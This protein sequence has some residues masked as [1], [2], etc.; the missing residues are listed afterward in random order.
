MRSDGV[1]INIPAENFPSN[2]TEFEQERW[3][4]MKPENDLHIAH[5]VAAEYGTDS[6]ARRVIGEI[7]RRVS[8]K[9]LLAAQATVPRPPDPWYRDRNFWIG[10]ISAAATIVAAY[11]T[12]RAIR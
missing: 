5:K 6:S 9:L 11:F 3:L 8:V 1:L 4:R 10:V 7:D 12:W 2:M